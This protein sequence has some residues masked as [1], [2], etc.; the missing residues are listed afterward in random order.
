MTVQQVDV[1]TLRTVLDDLVRVGPLDK[2][3][4]CR[5]CGELGL[6]S[7]DDTP[8]CCFCGGDNV[9]LSRAY[10]VIPDRPR[11]RVLG[12]RLCGGRLQVL[13]QWEGLPREWITYPKDRP[14]PNTWALVTP[15]NG[16]W[17]EIF[18]PVATRQNGGKWT[19]KWVLEWGFDKRWHTG[20]PWF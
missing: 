18:D 6:V 9:T 15:G 12:E 4:R 8:L 19:G 10:P 16:E 17:V 13:F 11:W 3:F 7:P 1:E 14:A 20:A 2:W 5:D